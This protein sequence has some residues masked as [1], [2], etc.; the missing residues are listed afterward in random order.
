[1]QFLKPDACSLKPLSPRYTCDRG[2]YLLVRV[3]EVGQL[4]G[5]VLLIGREVEVTV[6]AKVEENG[7]LL[8]GF[9]GSERQVY[10]GFDRMRHLGRRHYTLRPGEH[11]PGLE[12]GVLG[13]CPRLDESLVRQRRNYGGVAVVTQA[14]CM[15]AARHERVSQRVHLNH[16]GGACSVPEVVGVA[17]LRKR[18]ARGRLDGHDARALTVLQVL[19]DEGESDAAEV[20]AAPDTADDH[21]G[22]LAGQ[23]HL[24]ER[25]LPDHGLVQQHVVQDAPERVLGV[26]VSHSVLDSLAYGD[27]ERARRVRVLLQDVA[28]SVREVRGARVNFGPVSLHHNAPVWFLIVADAD[29]VDRAIEAHHPAGEREGRAPL[30]R[31][32][33]GG[34]APDTLFAVVIRLGDGRVRL[35][36]AGRRAALVLVVDVG[37]GVEEPLQTP[38]AEERGRAPEAID[39]THFFGDGNV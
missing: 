17:A 13:V 7:L 4:S 18:R 38:G 6:A 23:L 35:V 24:L 31:P 3:L 30:A 25:F 19:A 14:P 32:R 15:Y 36:A 11:D 39:L 27:P 8:S 33:L 26:V 22:V 10:G 5:E 1:M 16:R 29:H 34:Q 12:G 37:R 21:V 20:R 9:L 28:A 2:L